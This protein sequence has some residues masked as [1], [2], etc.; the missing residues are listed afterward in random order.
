MTRKLTPISASEG[1][2]PDKQAAFAVWVATRPD[3]VRKLADEFPIGT[4][5]NVSLPIPIAQGYD[6]PCGGGAA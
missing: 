1:V 3:V 6:A 5:G 4:V 2:E